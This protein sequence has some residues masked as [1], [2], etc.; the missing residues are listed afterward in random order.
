M[1]VVRQG[2]LSAISEDIR[3]DHKEE[4]DQ[5][6]AAVKKSMRRGHQAL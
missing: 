3:H 5:G 6:T 4:E 1:Q 2:Q